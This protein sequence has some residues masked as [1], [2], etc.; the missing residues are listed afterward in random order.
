[1]AMSRKKGRILIVDDE[2][3]LLTM[4]RW[5]FD[6]WGYQVA[7]AADAAT[8]LS[9]LASEAYDLVLT[10]MRMPGMDG[11][12]LTRIIKDRHPDMAVIIITGYAT[13]AGAVE[14]LKTGAE[15]Y[16]AKPFTD[17]ELFS[18]VARVLAGLYS[19]RESRSAG[20][21]RFG[22]LGESRG[23][24]QA[25]AAMEAAI[26]NTGPILIMGE[27]GSGRT[28]VARIICS[29]KKRGDSPW[30]T[31][32]CD[33]PEEFPIENP[34]SLP[35]G[36]VVTFVN[37]ELTPAC[38]R[39]KL[40]ESV[41]RLSSAG[42]LVFLLTGDAFQLFASRSQFL[43][44]LFDLVSPRTITLPPLRERAD[45]VYL[46]ADHFLSMLA[47]A[48]GANKLVFTPPAQKVLKEYSWP[49]N[50]A[51]L[52]A[53]LSM[54]ALQRVRGEI[55]LDDLP[56]TVRDAHGGPSER[57]LAQAESD[58]IL[59]VLSFTGGHMIKASAIL[60]I[61]R[62]TLREKMKGMGLEPRRRISIKEIEE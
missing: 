4:L 54:A 43:A 21:G 8:A 7:L 6:S 49:G 22:L 55:D 1:M 25:F 59:R 61:D 45:D 3:D 24:R 36:S 10:D 9:I 53:A 31:V 23:M 38:N 50:V 11:L 42:F 30:F 46:L 13:I 52:I 28:A 2:P 19:R 16:L 48:L 20:K 33:G 44:N 62:K 56:A 47:G 14:A 40:L 35:P 51:E 27:P 58:H 32:S 15:E 26:A 41:G 17:D 60:G 18:T 5:K 57:S 37:V 39:E 12:E 29:Q 34:E